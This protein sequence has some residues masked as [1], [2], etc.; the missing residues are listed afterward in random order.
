MARDARVKRA[1]AR[2]NRGSRG[3]V[4]YSQKR[5]PHQGWWY[6]GGNG[7]HLI[8]CDT[9][10]LQTPARRWDGPERDVVRA[11]DRMHA[12]A[13]RAGWYVGKH[14]KPVARPRQPVL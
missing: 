14:R 1:P 8:H 3:P 10:G 9:C 11:F 2:F 5:T 4:W 13:Q 12:A 6:G 7:S